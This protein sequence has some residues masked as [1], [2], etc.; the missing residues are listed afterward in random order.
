MTST[1]APRGF[2]D[3]LRGLPCSLAHDDGSRTLLPVD[4]WQAPPGAA[5]EALLLR[6]C[7]GPT[8]D[9]GCGPGRLVAALSVRGVVALGIDISPLA[10]ALTRGRGAMALHR[11]VHDRLPGEGRWC[12]ALLADGNIG[13]GGD[14]ARLLRRVGEL[15]RRGGTVLAELEPPGSGI[16]YGSARLVHHDTAGPS[17]PWCRV[18]ADAATTVANAADLR[19]LGVAHHSGRWAALLQRR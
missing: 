14:P 4:R 5:D 10:V 11:D 2:E 7:T 3:A 8:V 1:L 12:H 16:R 15:V 13:I 9:V 6:R 17:F 18:S 19:L